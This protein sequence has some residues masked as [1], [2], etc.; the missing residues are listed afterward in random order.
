[1]YKGQMMLYYNPVVDEFF[2]VK[3]G[4][5]GKY[6]MLETGFGTTLFKTFEEL[7]KSTTILE[8]SVLVEGD[9]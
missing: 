2:V 5:F 1:M 3:Y 8:N 7:E 4:I 9:F 6:F